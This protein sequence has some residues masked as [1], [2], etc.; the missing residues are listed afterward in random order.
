MTAPLTITI[1]DPRHGAALGLLQASHAHLASRY[2]P[3]A[4]FALD[5][6]ELASP[7]IRFLLAQSDGAA[8]G[9]AALAHMGDYAEIKSMF[10]TPAARGTGTG[11]ALMHRLEDEARAQ[12]LR[13][14]RLETGDDLYA[15]HRLYARHGFVVCGPFGSYVAG[16]HSV[17]MQKCL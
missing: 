2:P 16:P 4:I 6:D 17:F 14:L 13:C 5:P 10:V 12:N 7:H 15:A 1:A 8:L 9:C 11:A 3:E